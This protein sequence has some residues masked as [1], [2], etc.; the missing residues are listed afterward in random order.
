MS[1]PFG[2]FLMVLC[3]GDINPL[4]MGFLTDLHVRIEANSCHDPWAL[5]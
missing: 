1:L 4:L 2:F 5:E 3:I